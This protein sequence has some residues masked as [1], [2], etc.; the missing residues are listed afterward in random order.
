MR[1]AAGGPFFLHGRNR[2]AGRRR[3]RIPPRRGGGNVPA[4]RKVPSGFFAPQPLLAVP[5]GPAGAGRMFPMPLRKRGRASAA[6]GRTAPEKSA[7]RT[8]FE[9]AGETGA[10]RALHAALCLVPPG[11]A[12][13]CAGRRPDRGPYAAA[14]PRRAKK[15][16]GTAPSGDGAPANTREAGSP[17]WKFTL[18]PGARGAFP[19]A[20][21]P[22]SSCGARAECSC[23]PA[24]R[25]S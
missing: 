20:S 24:A 2:R 3:C 12:G 15:Y 10:E 1:P 23:T 6:K 16:A 13:R 19:R 14:A 21:C 7:G 8:A 11:I 22:S 18:R 5:G 25:R 4:V 17:A 9:M